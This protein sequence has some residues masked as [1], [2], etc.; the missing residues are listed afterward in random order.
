MSLISG[1]VVLVV[2][3]VGLVAVVGALL[4]V[5]WTVGYAVVSVGQWVAKGA[6]RAR[7]GR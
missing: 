7:K 4:W 6:R 5:A 3:A 2:V 1:L